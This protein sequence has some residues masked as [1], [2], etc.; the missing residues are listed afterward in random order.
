MREEFKSIE[1]NKIRTLKLHER[2]VDPDDEFGREVDRWLT[3]WEAWRDLCDH[4][5]AV[6]MFPDE[7]FKL[8][9][10]AEEDAPISAGMVEFTAEV[11]SR[12]LDGTY[13]TIYNSSRYGEN[14]FVIGKTSGTSPEDYLRM[15]RIAAECCVMLNGG[16]RLIDMPEDVYINI[17]HDDRVNA[18]EAGE[19][20]FRKY[21]EKYLSYIDS[22]IEEAYRSG[23]RKNFNSAVWY[24]LDKLAFDMLRSGIEHDDCT[25]EQFKEFYKKLTDDAYRL[26]LYERL[27]DELFKLHQEIEKA[28]NLA[29][30]NGM[31]FDAQP[32]DPDDEFDPYVYNPMRMSDEDYK[33]VHK[34]MEAD[35]TGVLEIR[36]LG[37][38]QLRQL[39][40]DMGWCNHVDNDRYNELLEYADKADITSADILYIAQR[41]D[42][43]TADNDYNGHVDSICCE[44]ARR[45]WPMFTI[46]EPNDE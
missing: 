40:I 23:D 3:N 22:D 14:N 43:F 28:R 25:D 34:E 6:G 33:L 30:E 19:Y 11:T 13:F 10:F 42:E 46:R 39:C 32:Y 5:E 36:K 31:A 37:H 20:S 12:E 26:R 2:A 27:A 16:G 41:I 29:H 7:Y 4:L 24:A 8:S 35:K 18:I 9:A 45:C 21:A 44:I 1:G 38:D 17:T 15:S